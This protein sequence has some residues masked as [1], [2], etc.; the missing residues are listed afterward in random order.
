MAFPTGRPESSGLLVEK[1]APAEVLIGKPLDYAYKVS[2]LLDSPIQMVTLFDRVTGNFNP[3]DADPKPSETKGGIVTWQLGTLAP[4]E[5]KTVH[6][7]G[8]AGTEGAIATCGWATYSPV[9]C[10]EIRVVRADMQLTASAPT[11]ALI[12]EPIPMTL[13]VKNTGSSTLNATK[14]AA[15]LPEGL[16]SDRRNAVAFDAGTL[17]PGQSREFR[18]NVTASR[19]G[20]FA[21][22]ARASTALG[23]VS[24][25][26]ASTMVSQ[27]ALAIAGKAPDERYAGRP[28]E[29]CFTVSNKSDADS[30][31]TTLEIPIPSGVSFKAAS[32]GGRARAGAVVWD[33]GLLAPNAAKEACATFASASAGEIAFTGTAKGLCAHSVSTTNQI[34]VVGVAAILLEKADDP[35]PIAVGETTTYTV[36]ITNQ[37]TADDT[38]VRT[39]VTLPPELAPASVTAGGAID[40]QTVSFPAVARL[41]PKDTITYKIVARGV[42]AGDGRTRFVLTSNILKSPVT[43]EEST[44]VY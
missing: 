19:P 26:S 10:E 11:N 39:V 33:L 41:A 3:A 40:G 34:H 29:I 12:C 35:D 21:I 22:G 17:A 7:R 15:T 31:G 37:G 6:V 25:A 44:H 38:N 27:P 36:K 4:R 32:A 8:N 1:T 23:L 5:T 43:A 20:T 14:A 30:S 42:K 24:E 18:F 9:L 13:I 2:N 28:F 16:T